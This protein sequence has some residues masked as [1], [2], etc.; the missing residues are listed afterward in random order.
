PTSKSTPPR[1]A[2]N[3]AKPHWVAQAG[4]TSSAMGACLAPPAVCTTMSPLVGTAGEDDRGSELVRSLGAGYRPMGPGRGE[5]LEQAAAP[6]P[7]SMRP[8]PIERDLRLDFFRGLSLFFIF[9][10]HIPNNVL[11]YG[12]LQAIAFAD[13]AEVFIFIS[14]YTAA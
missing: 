5:A 2:R 10:D 7:S 9:I 14:G 8:V 11:S 6:E 12:T 13:A 3:T 1:P 4:R